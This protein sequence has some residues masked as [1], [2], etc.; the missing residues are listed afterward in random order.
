MENAIF[1]QGQGVVFRGTQGSKLLLVKIFV[2]FGSSA[3]KNF[4]F[5]LAFQSAYSFASKYFALFCHDEFSYCYR[6]LR[7]F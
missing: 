7:S 4:T 5:D 1:W 3:P 2:Y 6:L